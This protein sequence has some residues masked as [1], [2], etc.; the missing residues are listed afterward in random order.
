MIN[1]VNYPKERE[2]K[3]KKKPWN[4]CHNSSLPSSK[5]EKEKAPHTTPTKKKKKKLKF[6]YTILYW[7]E[8]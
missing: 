2:R 6:G 8:I 5:W 1:H 3:K 4:P 7:F